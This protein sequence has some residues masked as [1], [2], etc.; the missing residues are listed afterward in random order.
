MKNLTVGQIRKA[1]KT[2]KYIKLR[3]IDGDSIGINCKA[4]F[5]GDNQNHSGREITPYV[6]FKPI[7]FSE[8]LSIK[9][10]FE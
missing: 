2:N 9:T 10:P 6:S 1:A 8:Y 3:Y 7:D 4:V 5:L